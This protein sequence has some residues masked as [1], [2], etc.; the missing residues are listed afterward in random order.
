MRRPSDV[1]YALFYLGLFAEARGEA[2]KAKHYMLQAVAAPYAVGTLGRGDY[3][4][5]VARVRAEHVSCVAYYYSSMV[6]VC[7]SVFLDKETVSH[8][9]NN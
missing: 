1:F 3:M 5:T 4:T 9:Q 2:T 7:A 8:K 6:C